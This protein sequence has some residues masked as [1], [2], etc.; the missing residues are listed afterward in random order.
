MDLGKGHP[1]TFAETA[2]GVVNSLGVF[3]KQEIQRFNTLLNVIRISLE[4]L[5]KAIEG[6]VV[7][8]MELESMFAKFIDGRVPDNWSNPMIG[9]P[10]LKPLG[11]WMKDLLKRIEFISSWLYKG[12]PLS[13]WIPAF[14][15]PQGFITATMQ[16]YARKNQVAIDT[17]AFK[18]HVMPCNVEGVKEAPGIGIYMHGLFMQ[19]ARWDSNKKCVDDSHIGIPIVEFPVI[20]LEPVLDDELK[21]DR[22]FTCPLYKT[23]VRAGELSTTGHSTNFCMYLAIPT[24]RD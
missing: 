22:M 12:P 4:Q 17:L 6:T 20:W 13:Y 24:E 18:T 19:G 5:A 14:F 9:Y 3:V 15:F 2:P 11:S 23:S 7:M 1:L 16:T 8:S 21:L 10:C